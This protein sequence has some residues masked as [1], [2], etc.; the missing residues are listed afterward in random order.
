MLVDTVSQKVIKLCGKE[1][2]NLE[3][4]LMRSPNLRL[5]DISIGP[6]TVFL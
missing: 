3:K 4:R 5:W 1:I 6:K 2:K